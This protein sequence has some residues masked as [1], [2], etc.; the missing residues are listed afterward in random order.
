METPIEAVLFHCPDNV[1]KFPIKVTQDKY[2]IILKKLQAERIKMINYLKNLKQRGEINSVFR[3]SNKHIQKQ[4]DEITSAKRVIKH[5]IEKIKII[6][7]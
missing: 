6:Y 2:L 5:S 4:L 3:P 7:E 1:E